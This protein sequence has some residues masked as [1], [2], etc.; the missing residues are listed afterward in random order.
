LAYI[1]SNATL[2][3]MNWSRPVALLAFLLLTINV[4][5]AGAVPFA[6][7]YG[8]AGSEDAL[9]V[10]VVSATP[11]G[12]GGS[13]PY[14]AY[15]AGFIFSGM[16]RSF[17]NPFG[18]TWVVRLDSSGTI[19][20]Q[21]AYNAVGSL[22]SISRSVQQTLDGG[23]IVAGLLTPSIGTNQAWVVKLFPD[24]S[25]DWQRSYSGGQVANSITQIF[26]S[27]D[28][29]VGGHSTSDDFWVARLNPIGVPVWEYAYGGLGYDE[30]KSV[31]QVFP[32]GD[33]VVVGTSELLPV[34]GPDALVLEINPANA[35]SAVTPKWG[36]LYGGTLT[37]EANSVTQLLPS[38][39][40]VVV[41][42]TS[43]FG[44]G[45]SDAW[46]MRLNPNSTP[47]GTPVWEMAY[48]GPQPDD[49]YSVT[50]NPFCGGG[51][52]VAGA[53][54]SAP[55]PPSGGFIDGWLFQLSLAGTLSTTFDRTYGGSGGDF[56][57]TVKPIVGPGFVVSGLAGSTSAFGAGGQDA[58]VLR[59]NCQGTI[60]GCASKNFGALVSPGVITPTPTSVFTPIS[61]IGIT[62]GANMSSGGTSTLSPGSYP[63]TTSALTTGYGPC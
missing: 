40:L 48:G 63:I 38:G 5:Q 47:H 50:W 62:T 14:S 53:T 20:W 54:L 19:L 28:Y 46:V 21:K 11:A 34:F 6:K 57:V 35:A 13:G 15:S 24:G 7:T 31:I 30:A 29:V 27:G 3:I 44:A 22:S 52:I 26:P 32:S 55:S 37:E 45:L 58:L 16:T 1:A 18:D 8:G 56:A 43:S 41:G 39:D 33:V 61:T 25:V 51:L 10:G 12:V 42:G 4:Q 60:P 2:A 36:A 17:G 59:T 23:F 9:S 49:A